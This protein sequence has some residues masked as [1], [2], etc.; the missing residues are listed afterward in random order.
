MANIPT[1]KSFK[2]ADDF[3]DYFEREIRRHK[4][5]AEVMDTDGGRLDELRKASNC[6]EMLSHVKRLLGGTGRR[7]ERREFDETTV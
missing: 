5:R 7:I 2:S 3:Y 6:K 1:R 4:I